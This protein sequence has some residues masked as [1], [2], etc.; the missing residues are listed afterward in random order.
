MLTIYVVLSVRKESLITM[1]GKHEAKCSRGACDWVVGQ[2]SEV[3]ERTFVL[4]NSTAFAP[5]AKIGGT[6]MIHI[7]PGQAA[8]NREQTFSC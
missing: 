3:F 4:V 2:V 7:P 8:Y 6:M 5:G 1:G